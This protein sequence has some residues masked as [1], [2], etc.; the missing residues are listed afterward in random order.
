[1]L[2]GDT[3]VECIAE[4]E[5]SGFKMLHKPLSAEQLRRELAQLIKA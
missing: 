1:M 4:I 5:A 2:T 3:A